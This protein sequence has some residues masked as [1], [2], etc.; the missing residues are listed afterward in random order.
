MTSRND[1]FRRWALLWRKLAPFLL[2]TAGII[3]LS[4]SAMVWLGLAA[5][6][7]TAGIGC[8]V[9]NFR[10]HEGRRSQ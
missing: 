6:M 4:G 8:F 10:I 2:D 3:L 5:G 1:R 9:L 7:A